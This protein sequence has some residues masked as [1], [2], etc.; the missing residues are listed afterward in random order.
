MYYKQIGFED[1][2]YKRLVFFEGLSNVGKTT[3]LNQVKKQ[4][5]TVGAGVVTEVVK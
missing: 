1:T 5:E 3:I 4:L 2:F